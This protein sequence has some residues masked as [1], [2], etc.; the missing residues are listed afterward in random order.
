MQVIID[1]KEKQVI[2]TGNHMPAVSIILPLNVIKSLEHETKLALKF[3]LDKVKKQLFDNYPGERASLAINR[4]KD[5]ISNIDYTLCKKSLAI[6]V[7]PVKEEVFYLDIPVEERIVINESFEIRDLIYN[8]KANQAVLVLLLSGE[9][10]R[11][12]YA[13]GKTF[14]S[15]KIPVADNVFAYKT[16]MPERTGNFSDPPGHKEIMLNKF[17]HHIDIGLSGIIKQYNYPV[18]VLGAKRVLG[19]FKKITHHADKIVQFIHGNFFDVRENEILETVNS[20]LPVLQQ[21]REK[22]FLHLLEEAA[23]KGVLVCG[24]NNLWAEGNNKNIRL[25]IVEK[26]FNFPVWR[27]EGDDA[28]QEQAGSSDSFYFKDAVDDLMQK[29]LECGGDIEFTG[30]GVL[31]KYEGAAAILYHR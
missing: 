13:F 31:G 25:L 8:K 11:I 15:V 22:Y 4:L 6:F 20:Y 7:S 30:N 5:V 14:K 28:I 24:I 9:F 3:A 19:H 21:Q 12:Y 2:E 1:E 26:D 16:D 29:V 23:G 18:F 10:A 17:L 27:G